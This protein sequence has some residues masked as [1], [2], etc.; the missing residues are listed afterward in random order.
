MPPSCSRRISPGA[1]CTLLRMAYIWSKTSQQWTTT[2]PRTSLGCP[3]KPQPYQHVTE[4]CTKEMLWA[5]P[6]LPPILV[7][8]S[9]LGP[10][11]LATFVYTFRLLPLTVGDSGHLTARRVTTMLAQCE[12]RIHIDERPIRELSSSTFYCRKLH[13]RQLQHRHHTN[14][15]LAHV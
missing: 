4:E 1:A 14:R 7:L 11:Y 13:L 5:R 6:G 2:Y 15:S 8:H 12:V 10:R 9:G 3:P